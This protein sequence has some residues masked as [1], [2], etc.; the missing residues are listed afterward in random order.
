MF[1]DFLLLLRQQRIKIGLTEWLALSEA[2]EKGLV[3][4]N[5]LSF[6]R[7][8]RAICIKSEAQFDT[9]DQCFAYFFDGV[10]M[11]PSLSEE[12]LDWLKDQPLPPE[13]DPKKLAEM[14]GLSLDELKQMFEQRLKEQTERH[15]GG[16]RW[17]GTGGTSPFG[18]SGIHPSGVRVGG[19]SL[20][21]RAMQ[22]A[23]KRKFRNLRKDRVLDV[24]QIGLALK[25][26][27]KLEHIGSRD[28]L[29]I[30]ATIAATSKN[31]GDI[32]IVF[33]AA[34]KNSVKLLVMMDVGGSMTFHSRL[35]ETLF[36]AAHGISH[37]QNLKFLFFH[38][39]PYEFLYTNI[40]LEEKVS[41]LDALRNLD[42]GWNLMMIG[43]AAMNPYELLAPGGSVDYYHQ[44][45]EPGLKWLQRLRSKFPRSV[46][47]NP[48]PKEYWEIPSSRIVR[49]VFPNMHPLTV[50]GIEDAI[51]DLLKFQKSFFTESA[52]R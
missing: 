20:T 3:E 43:D 11:K 45:E 38:N 41:T 28:E 44:N 15:D 4:Q 17:I 9:F 42:D 22:V 31:A 49:G 51:D 1:I 10:E 33:K 6:Y 5:L 40:E 52:T 27:R 21:R 47:L 24:R 36:S 32:D 46:W 29:D 18:H 37:F 48:E 50:D 14:S 30:E 23:T 7:V 2:L 8:S 26:L 19:Q 13:L 12:L 39:C 34:R 16:N 35:S 25:R